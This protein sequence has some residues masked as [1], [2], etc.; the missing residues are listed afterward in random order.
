MSGDQSKRDVYILKYQS[1]IKGITAIRLDALPDERLPEHGPGRVYYEGPPGDFFLSDFHVYSGGN[2]LSI[3]NATHSTSGGK[4]ESATATIDGDLQ[5]GWS[6]GGGRG[7]AHWAVFRLA[8]P[9]NGP[10]NFEIKLVFERYYASGLG[11]FRIAVTTD[12]RPVEAR[13][14][15]PEIEQI[16]L[17]S[18]SNRTA[19]QNRRLL[20]QYLAVAPELAKERAAI[21]EL[22]K[23][24]PNSPTTLVLQ[25]RPST[26]P[27]PTFVH[28]RGE[29]LQPTD[30][31]EPGVLSILPRF[32]LMAR[33][34]GSHWRVG[35]FPRRIRSRAAW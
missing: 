21:D 2:A 33:A 26:N 7:K 15:P 30:R 18:Q 25:E 20:Q 27:R 28:N 23:T 22:R 13:G 11:K 9:I 35:L 19:D 24:E 6:I 31:V 17:I 16:L 32:R 34:T 8:G 29:Y 10:G 3:K 5:S 1:D 4:A 14:V 12:P